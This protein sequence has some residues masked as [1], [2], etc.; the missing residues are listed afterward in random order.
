MLI[1]PRNDRSG[2]VHRTEQSVTRSC[3]SSNNQLKLVEDIKNRKYRQ[4]LMLELFTVDYTQFFNTT[5][6]I[7]DIVYLQVTCLSYYP[8]T[9]CMQPIS[10]AI[11]YNHDHV[12]I[13][14]VPSR[15][16]V[17]LFVGVTTV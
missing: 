7:G 9:D 13:C 2:E 6:S 17:G 3:W 4:L 12:I 15:S 14:S 1:H 5:A 16:E 11:V 10:L 8:Q